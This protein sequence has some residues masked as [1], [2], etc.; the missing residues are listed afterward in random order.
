MDNTNLQTAIARFEG[1]QRA[2]DA[3][4]RD[5]WTLRPVYNGRTS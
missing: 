4:D 5:R 2:L 1:W 3:A